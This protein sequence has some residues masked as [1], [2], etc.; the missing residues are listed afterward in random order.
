MFNAVQLLLTLF[1]FLTGIFKVSL[2]K[3]EFNFALDRTACG[4]YE[5]SIC[6][7]EL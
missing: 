2:K 1:Q 4:M 5:T 6:L 3:L 7:H